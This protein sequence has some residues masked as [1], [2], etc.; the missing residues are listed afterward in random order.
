MEVIL[1]TFVCVLLGFQN[2]GEKMTNLLK[3]RTIKELEILQEEESLFV[4][5][6]KTILSSIAIFGL[7]VMLIGNIYV[8]NFFGSTIIDIILLNKIGLINII[9]SIVLIFLMIINLKI[10]VKK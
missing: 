5:K 9:I 1:C 3:P 4:D 2:Q 10:G 6:I 7:V 8:A